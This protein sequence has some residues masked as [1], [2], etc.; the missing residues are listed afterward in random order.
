LVGVREDHCRDAKLEQKVPW[1]P[2]PPLCRIAKFK[3]LADIVKPLTDATKWKPHPEK[4]ASKGLH[5]RNVITAYRALEASD[6][7]FKLPVVVDYK[8][9]ERFSTH[10]LNESP[11]LTRTRAG[12]FGYWCSTKGASLTLSEMAS[13]QGFDDDDFPWE[14]AGMTKTQAAQMLGNG[15]T[16]P[17]VM[18]I[19]VHLLY[20]SSFLTFPKYCVLKTKLYTKWGIPTQ[21]CCQA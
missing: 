11:T 3:S 13:L 2:P 19:L 14:A 16:L 12:Q 21:G 15:Q 5:Y 20:Q 6:N 18:D 8:A 7:P 1:F 9:S 4:N 17:V 10:R